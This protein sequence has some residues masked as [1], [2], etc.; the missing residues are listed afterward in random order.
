MEDDDEE[1]DKTRKEAAVDGL[2]DAEGDSRFVLAVV[3]FTLS[4]TLMTCA[5]VNVYCSA[6]CSRL[7]PK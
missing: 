3:A 6:A 5:V 7:C 4:M 1:E 2:R